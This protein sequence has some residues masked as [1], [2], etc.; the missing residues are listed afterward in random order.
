MFIEDTLKTPK[1]SHVLK[2]VFKEGVVL[3]HPTLLYSIKGYRE[4]YIQHHILILKYKLYTKI[5]Q[6]IHHW[7]DNSIISIFHLDVIL[8]P[9][10][11]HAQIRHHI[12]IIH[13]PFCSFLDMSYY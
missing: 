2:D 10:P 4:P 12:I 7:I 13:D 3:M 5:W 6:D 1:C 8:T 9:Y 11:Y